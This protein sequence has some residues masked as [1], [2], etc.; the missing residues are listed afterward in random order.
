L[1]CCHPAK[2]V[3][4]EFSNGGTSNWLDEKELHLLGNQLSIKSLQCVIEGRMVVMNHK[5]KQCNCLEGDD[6]LGFGEAHICEIWFVKCIH[7]HLQM[8][9]L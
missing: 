8:L 2:I 3:D 9:L 4:L 7:H 6:K 5:T 1:I